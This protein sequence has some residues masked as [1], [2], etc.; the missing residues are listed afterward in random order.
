MPPV[1]IHF[2]RCHP[3]AVTPKFVH[4][5]DSGFDFFTVE[6]VIIMGGDKAVLRTGIKV[7]LPPGYEIQIRPRSGISAKT[8]I[9]VLLGTIDSGYRGELGVIVE[10][11][12]TRNW[13]IK[14]GE[15]IGQGIVARVPEVVFMEV[16]EDQLTPS[17]RGEGGFGS[18]GGH[19]GIP[20]T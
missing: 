8:P 5:G 4:V 16:E 7:E 20:C 14:A 17:T 12:G 1:V 15:R 19:R 10:N 2:A 13:R 18:S 11:T 9:N 3:A 6:D